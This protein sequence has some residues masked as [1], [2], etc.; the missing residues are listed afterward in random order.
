[1]PVRPGCCATGDLEVDEC[2]RSGQVV[3]YEK[4]LENRNQVGSGDSSDSHASQ[5][6]GQPVHVLLDFEQPATIG[7]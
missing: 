4:L 3:P 2:V 5:A 7:A 1:M 6:V